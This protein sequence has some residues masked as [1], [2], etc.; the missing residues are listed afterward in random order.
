MNIYQSF[1][2]S[3][4]KRQTQKNPKPLL[5]KAYH[6]NC[7]LFLFKI[8]ETMGLKNPIDVT[9]VPNLMKINQSVRKLIGGQADR[10]TDSVV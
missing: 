10:H 4:W 6:T 2:T 8:V 5:S 3:W 7:N 9:S 1:N